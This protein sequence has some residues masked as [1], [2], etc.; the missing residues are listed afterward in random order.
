M[1]GRRHTNSNKSNA[2]KKTEY[3]TLKETTAVASLDHERGLESAS[4]AT[5]QR[6]HNDNNDNVIY[7]YQLKVQINWLL[8]LVADKNG[9][10]CSGFS[11]S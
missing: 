3:A 9:Y 7:V 5:Y 2:K 4:I 1:K 11:V 6:W 10:F 8:G